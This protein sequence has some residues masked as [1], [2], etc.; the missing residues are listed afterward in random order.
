VK[1]LVSALVLLLGKLPRPRR[2]VRARIVQP[3]DANARAELVAIFL[4][5]ASAVAAVAFVVVY[6]LDEIAHQT[7]YLGLAIGAAFALAAAACVLLAKKVIATEELEHE[8][9]DHAHELEQ[10]QVEQIVAESGEPITR[11]RLL[12]LGAGAAGTAL[13]AALLAPAASLGPLL[14]SDPLVRTP[15]RRG[16]LLVDEVGRALHADEIEE[17]AFYTAYPLHA[18]REQLGA[19]LV[20]VRLNPDEL[21][22]PPERAG[23]APGGIVAYSKICTHAG[24]AIALY[25]KPTFEQTQPRPAL[26]CPCHY[27]TF[28]PARA[29]E[30]IF[31]PAGRNLPQLPLL[32]DRSG[33]LRAAGNFSG[34]VGPSWWKVRKRKATT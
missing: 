5:L 16:R 28:D 3:H 1:W 10:E 2:A 6:A 21:Q 11:K 22:L 23:W 26:I 15:W 27:S 20:V 9:P 12:F 34:P 13:S 33:R 14:E 29:G 19:P 31:G 25:R 30:V 32:V 7:Q 4:L 24:C 18:D 8:Y 17:E